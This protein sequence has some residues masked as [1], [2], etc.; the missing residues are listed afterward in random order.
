MP[1]KKRIEENEQYLDDLL[2]F[3]NQ[4]KEFTNSLDDINNKLTKLNKYYGSKDWFKDLKE[5][6]KKKLNIKAGVLSEDGVWN[7]N[8]N[9]TESLQELQTKLKEILNTKN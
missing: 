8:E 9:L 4:T 1:M 6:D 5:Y 7:M 2:E 3:I